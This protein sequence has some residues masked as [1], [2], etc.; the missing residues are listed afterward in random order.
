MSSEKQ[1]VTDDS[2]RNPARDVEKQEPALGPEKHHRGGIVSILAVKAGEVYEAHPEKNP[3]WYQKLLD[4][5][6]EENG[7]KPVPLESRTN[8][9][10]SN[11]FT[12]FCTCLLSLLPWVLVSSS[13]TR[14]MK[15]LLMAK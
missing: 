6:V 14:L 2:D 12:V 4:L 7:V 8:T 1:A 9:N 13:A 3:K 10:Y 5:G 11:L 15:R